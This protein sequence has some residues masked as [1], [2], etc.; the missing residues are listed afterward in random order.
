MI[1][2][3]MRKKRSST[4]GWWQVGQAFAA[5]LGDGGEQGLGIG[6]GDGTRFGQDDG[7]GLV[8]G[9]HGL[10]EVGLGVFVGGAEDVLVVDWVRERGLSH[11]I[12]DCRF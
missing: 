2:A 8:R 1:R 7:V 6:G 10:E 11:G 4:P 5:H 12:L 9:E 3:S